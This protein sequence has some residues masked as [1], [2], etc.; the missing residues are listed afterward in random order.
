MKFQKEN[1]ASLV[2][3]VSMAVCLAACGDDSKDEANPAQPC[4]GESCA[5]QD[6]SDSGVIPVASNA[7]K[8]DLATQKLP[9]SSLAWQPTF[10]GGCEAQQQIALDEMLKFDTLLI[11]AGFQKE[12]LVQESY[13][14]VRETPD[15]TMLVAVNDTLAFTYMMGT[16]VGNFHSVTSPLDEKVLQERF[17]TPACPVLLPPDALASDVWAGADLCTISNKN[18][19]VYMSSLMT[20]KSLNVVKNDLAKYGWSC[21]GTASVTC[22]AT[23][24]SQNYTLS[25]TY[26][27]SINGANLKELKL[28]WTH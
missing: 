23:Y 25:F 21:V 22:S 24:D 15:Y 19:F 20:S 7:S 6:S 2:F 4:I 10:S 16:F 17:V 8:C 3:F 9:A 5:T 18:G 11:A 12:E 26:A 28:M 1:I 27:S 13:R 14:Y